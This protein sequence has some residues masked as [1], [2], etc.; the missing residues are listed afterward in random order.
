MQ[1]NFQRISISD[2]R[3]TF[4]GKPP[5]ANTIKKWI[6]TNEVQGEVL[7]SLY[8]LHLDH[9][10]HLIPKNYESQVDNILLAKLIGDFENGSRT[11]T[12]ND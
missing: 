11:K 10:G 9:D 2:F 5:C 12:K 1:V 6:L 8:F 7:G 4:A 3:K